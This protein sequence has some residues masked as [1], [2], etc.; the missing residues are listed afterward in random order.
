[1]IVE[2]YSLKLSMLSR[3]S[4]SFVSYPRDEMSRFVTGVADLAKEECRAAMRHDDMTLAGLMV[5]AQSIEESK[6]CRIARNLKSCFSSD[7]S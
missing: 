2:E 4:L 5:Y 1:M 7:Q 6:L 3:F